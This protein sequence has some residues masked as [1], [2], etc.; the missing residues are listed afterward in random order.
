[1]I[2]FDAAV[3]IEQWTWDLGSILLNVSMWSHTTKVPVVVLRVADTPPWEC[4][5][6]KYHLTVTL[7]CDGRDAL[8]RDIFRRYLVE[9]LPTGLDVIERGN[10]LHVCARPFLLRK[11]TVN[12]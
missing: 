4:T 12:T 1:M 8:F 6:V 5:D 7:D 10:T 2:R 3:R 9:H 11:R